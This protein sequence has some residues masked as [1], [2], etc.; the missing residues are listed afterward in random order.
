M[1]IEVKVEVTALA[2]PTRGPAPPSAARCCGVGVVACV[3]I[4]RHSF[5]SLVGRLK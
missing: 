5:E 4:V 3:V 1:C 2:S